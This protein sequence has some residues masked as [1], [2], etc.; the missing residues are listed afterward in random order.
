MN[1][2]FNTFTLIIRQLE[3]SPATQLLISVNSSAT[4][5]IHITSLFI[6]Y[7]TR[8]TTIFCE[9]SDPSVNPWDNRMWHMYPGS[10]A[11]F[12]NTIFRLRRFFGWLEAFL[13]YLSLDSCWTAPFFFFLLLCI[14]CFYIIKQQ[15]A[16]GYL[17][18]A[19]LFDPHPLHASCSPAEERTLI[20][21]YII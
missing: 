15:T 1:I 19:S 21:S 20:F 11:K 17:R 13:Q 7:V 3:T 10:D 5:Y 14:V 8:T 18:R 4:H 6:H 9:E 2:R 12:V 16:P